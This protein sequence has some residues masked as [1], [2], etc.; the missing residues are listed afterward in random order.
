MMKTPHLAIPIGIHEDVREV[1]AQLLPDVA[2]DEEK[3]VPHR[4]AVFDGGIVAR[5]ALLA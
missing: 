3:G 2:I 1:E 5:L 4:V